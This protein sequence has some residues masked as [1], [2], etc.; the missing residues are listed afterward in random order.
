MLSVAALICTY[1]ESEIILDCIHNLTQEGIDCY[2]L[3]DNS[4]DCTRKILASRID[5]G[6]SGVIQINR[7]KYLNYSQGRN[8]KA[9]A[10]LSLLLDYDWFIYIDVDEI[11]LS[12]YTSVSLVK[13][14]EKVGDE[15]YD[16][17]NFKVY[18]FRPTPEDTTS[19]NDYRNFLF[20]ENAGDYDTRQI[21]AWR[22]D[23]TIDLHTHA[24]H[25]PLFSTPRRLYPTR[26][27][28]KH[29]PIRSPQHYSKKIITER[30]MR[31]SD[32]ERRKGWH[33][34]YDSMTDICPVWNSEELC[35][36]DLEHERAKLQSE[37]SICET[38]TYKLHSQ[39]ATENLNFTEANLR[40][41]KHFGLQH[42]LRDKDLI[43]SINAALRIKYIILNSK[44]SSFCTFARPAH[45][46]FLA[47]KMISAIEYL[48]GRPLL[49]TKLKA[50]CSSY[51][52]FNFDAEQ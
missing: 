40:I 43:D 47:L 50:L 33:I 10:Q 15:G 39:Y 5:D 24:G 2:I 35:L 18:N 25:L 34:Q 31:F 14:I 44:T 46:V 19:N 9:V 30:K 26:F 37:S 11:R 27:I 48:E 20:Y 22:A 16:L 42:R 7:G 12:P 1:N 13:G 41:F 32:E 45:I 28:L 6:V 38:I 8:M 17:I 23:R 21:K 3:D 51:W 52:E 4:S 49:F 29:Y 36:F